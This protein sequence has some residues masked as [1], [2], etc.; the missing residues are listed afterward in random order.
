MS[1]ER[2]EVTFDETDSACAFL[3]GVEVRAR[4]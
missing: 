2:A 4:C 1:R 3:R